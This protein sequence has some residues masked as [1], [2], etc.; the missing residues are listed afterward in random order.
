M[1]SDGPHVVRHPGTSGYAVVLV[2]GFMDDRHIWDGVAAALGEAGTETV[3]LDL[4]GSGTHSGADGPFTY[5]R[6]AAD[7]VEVLDGLTEPVVLVGQSMG[8]VVAELAAAARPHATRALVLLTPVPAAGVPMSEEMRAVFG[9]DELTAEYVEFGRTGFSVAMPEDALRQQVATALRMRV[10]T[11]RELADC[12]I[13]GHP[14]GGRP[15]AY[16]GPVLVVR[17]GGDPFVTE[18]LVKDAVLPR[19]PAPE[20]VTVEEVG[21]WPHAERPAEVAALL[22]AFLARR[23]ERDPWSPVGHP[24]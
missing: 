16:P 9:P 4:A 8:A 6:L 14:D 19:F 24:S 7:V 11:A 5:D 13:D 20:Y 17:G 12:W 21:H 22:G 23:V 15:S 10:S 18:R 3:R 1:S 2:H